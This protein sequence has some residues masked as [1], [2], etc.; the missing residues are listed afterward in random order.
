M[1][2]ILIGI[3]VL[4]LSANE[5]ITKYIDVFNSNRHEAC[6]QAKAEADN[7][8]NMIERS[9]CNCEKI[10]YDG[11][12]CLVRYTYTPEPSNDAKD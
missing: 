3:T 6:I 1:K 11:W 4:N 10:D 9:G 2:M 5:A 12:R 8:K 7:V